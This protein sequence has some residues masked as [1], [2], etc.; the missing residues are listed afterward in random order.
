MNIE[1]TVETLSTALADS[2][3]NIQSASGRPCPET[4]AGTLRPI[5]DLDGFDSVNGVEATVLL[6]A[7]LGTSLGTDNLFVSLDGN[8]GLQIV[9]IAKRILK[10]LKARAA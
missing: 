10:K 3:R 6:E 1:W 8:S 7:Q 5:G 2:L 9:E 4:L